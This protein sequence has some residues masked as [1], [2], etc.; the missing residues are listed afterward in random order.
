MKNFHLKFILL[1]ILFYSNSFSQTLKIVYNESTPPLKFTD[2]NH[3]ANGILID[4]WKFWASKNNI[5][6]AF[7]ASSW[8]ESL[9]MIEDGRA[10]IHAGLYYTKSRDLKLD[11]S[12]QILF[13]NK[14]YFFYNKQIID[15]KSIQ[16][17]NPFVIGLG[18]GYSTPYMKKNYPKL[19][20]KLYD[21]DEE[22]SQAFIDKEV[23]VVL[24]SMATM[25]YFIKKNKYDGVCNLKIE[26]NITK[27]GYYFLSTY[28]AYVYK[29]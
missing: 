9:K 22:M 10:D 29:K 7:I 16:E 21:T 1:F 13:K 28:D 5:D 23:N 27:D 4:I 25:T 6:I 12:K 15:P 24:S 14:N 8:D 17:L 19:S 11:Y 26:F 18:N 20:T 2:I 3:Q